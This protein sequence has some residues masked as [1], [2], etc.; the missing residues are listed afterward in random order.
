MLVTVTDCVVGGC[1]L[2]D[3]TFTLVTDDVEDS[4]FL[5]IELF[6]TADDAVIIL[7]FEM[8][9]E[10]ETDGVAASVFLEATLVIFIDVAEFI[11]A[12]LGK[13]LVDVIVNE[14]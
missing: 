12:L 10:E 1:P 6:N 14:G 3:T 8:T 7:L 13:I 5:D 9:L 4:S 2:L 11:T